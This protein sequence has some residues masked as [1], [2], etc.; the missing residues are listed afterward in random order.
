MEPSFEQA[1][2]FLDQAILSYSAGQIEEAAQQIAEAAAMLHEMQLPTALGELV[3][4]V[5][6]P[7]NTETS[8]VMAYEAA[9]APKLLPITA[10]GAPAEIQSAEKPALAAAA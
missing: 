9:P 3:P 10:A 7:V 6:Q 5:F 1:S 2:A 4:E 8:A